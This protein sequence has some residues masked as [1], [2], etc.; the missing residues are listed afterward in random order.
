MIYLNMAGFSFRSYPNIAWDIFI[1]KK[2][3]IVNSDA[4]LSSSDESWKGSRL[5]YLKNGEHKQFVKEMGG[6]ADAIFW[7]MSPPI[8]VLYVKTTPLL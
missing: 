6:Y 4:K 7:K 3:V 5:G 1:T 2:L 8:S